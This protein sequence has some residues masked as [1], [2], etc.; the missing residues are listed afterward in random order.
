MKRNSRTS[1]NSTQI[2]QADARTDQANTR[3]DEANKRTERAESSEQG[4]RSSE[5]RYRRLFES[6]KDGILILDAETGMILDANP[7]LIELL[8]ISH[9]TFLGRKVWELG[10]FRDIAANEAKFAELQAKGYVRYDDMPLETA[11]GRRIGVE[12]VSNVYRENGHNVIQC[13]IRDITAYKLAAAVLSQSEEKYRQYF[14]S[15]HDAIMTLAFPSNRFTS[16]NPAA[17]KLFGAKNEL[18]FI[19]CTPSQLSPDRQPDGRA[20]AEKAKEMIEKAAH[21]GSSFFEWTHRRIGGQEFFADVLLTAM[22]RNG[23]VEVQAT[24]RDLTERKRGEADKADLAAIVQSSDDAIIGKDLQGIVTSWNAAAE[25]IFGYQANEMVGQPIT[26]L[27]SRDR[28][29]EEDEILDKIRNGESVQHYETVRLCKS[30]ASID[31]SLTVSP[32]KDPTG[33]ITGT[34]K[35]VRNITERKR[36]E[37]V[38]QKLSSIVEASPDFIGFSSLE[39]LVAYINP[40]GRKLVGLDEREQ[41]NSGRVLDYV[42]ETDRERFQNKILPA[43]FR[44]G[45]WDG[46]TL[47]KN[48]KTGAVICVSQRIFFITEPGTDQ[49][50]SI[51][52]IVRDITE[53]NQ[54]EEALRKSESLLKETGR[55]AH[56]GGWEFQIDTLGLRWT[57]EVYQ[58]HEVD[59]TYVPT[60][61]NALDFYDLSSR[62]IIERAVQRAIELGEPFDLELGLI[63]AKGNLRWVHSIGRVDQK[64]GTISG[65]FQDI[66][67]RI[68][69][70]KALRDSGEQFRAT[71]EVASIGMA[72]T[73]GQTGQFLRVNRKMLAVW[74][75]REPS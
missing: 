18:E 54:A 33:R 68:Q 38:T 21:E 42:H 44:D 25:R 26:R 5:L 72:Q 41:V 43:L 57:E 27:F 45:Y 50:K 30:G 55:I 36:A 71:F 39:G 24:V 75:E 60:V 19:S 17:V 11:D 9:T 70:E 56:I 31:V 66:T 65:T 15:S 40:A 4:M 20:S 67:E 34:S 62:P 13:D 48:L 2:K 73:D 35:V 74:K 32:I 58:T 59:M 52:T 1:D 46:E 14:E 51:A 37:V 8:G 22:E 3:T 7:F 29:H 69:G 16:G 64:R 53:R 12:F 10:I 63:T 6:A 23:K 28:Q 47:F 49:R 61:S